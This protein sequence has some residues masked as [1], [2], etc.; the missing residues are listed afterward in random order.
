VTSDTPL[1]RW[2]RDRPEVPF[3]FFRGPRGHFEW[4]SFR[5]A[6]EGRSQR[7]RD[8]SPLP[9]D[10]LATLEQLREPRAPADSGA[11]SILNTAGERGRDVVVSWR[12]I[13]DPGERSFVEWATRAGAAIV[14]E[15]HEAIPVD[16]ILWARPTVLQGTHSDLRHFASEVDRRAPNWLRRRWLR[17]RLGRLR[18]L[19]VEGGPADPSTDELARALARLDPELAAR[20]APARRAFGAAAPLV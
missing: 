7:R 13:D 8:E 6:A 17:R 3:L 4:L 20:L 14:V 16:L 10:L 15:R 19:I 11:A 5:E 2:A 18:A 1:A 12:S 9:A